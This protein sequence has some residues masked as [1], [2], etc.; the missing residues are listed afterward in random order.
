MPTPVPS[1]RACLAGEAARAL[2]DAVAVA[3]RRA[4]AQT[5]SLHVVSALLSPSFSSTLLRDALARARSAAYSPRL[6]F[7]ALELCFGVALDRLSSAHP[8]PAEPPVSNSLM[9]AIKRSQANQR[10]NPDTFHLYN[11][12]AAAGGTAAAVVKVELQPMVMAILDDPV[13]SRV[14][15]EAGFRSYDIKLSVLRPPSPIL[16]FPR[17]A[18]CPPLF[19]CNFDSPDAGDENCRR[20]CEILS[21]TT[22]NNPILVGVGA[23]DAARDFARALELQ[24]P[25]VVPPELQGVKTVNIEKGNEGDLEEMVRNS[26]GKGLVLSVGDLKGLVEDEGNSSSLVAAVTKVVTDRKAARVWVMGW[27]ATYEMYMKLLSLHPSLDKA[28]N[29]Q[30]LPITSLKNGIGSFNTRPQSLMESFVP[31]GGFFPLAYESKGSLSSQYQSIPRCQLCNEMYEQELAAMM[32][33]YSAQAEEQDKSNL[34]SWLQ[35]AET[36]TTEKGLH[37]AEA[38]DGNAMLN[39][40]IEDLQQKWNDNCKRLHR[41]FPM[42][43]TDTSRLL[44][45]LT[46]LHCVPDKGI[47]GCQCSNTTVNQKQSSRD[48]KLPISND[49]QIASASSSVSV[50]VIS[51]TKD[52][53]LSRLQVRVPEN[54][55]LQ[56]KECCSQP[57]TQ[58]DLIPDDH[59]SPSV[60]SV[61]TDLVLGTPRE[62]SQMHKERLQ[63]FSE[64]SPSKR[65]DSLAR[66]IPE[67]LQSYSYS[68]SPVSQAKVTSTV[69]NAVSPF[70]KFSENASSVCRQSDP[71]DYKAILRGLID[72]VG[73]QEEAICAIT[74]AILRCKTGPERL[75]GASLKGDIWLSFLGPDKVAKQRIAVALSELMFGSMEN[76]IHVD[77]CVQDSVVRPNVICDL[78]YI[79]GYDMKFRGK[80]ITDHIAAVVSKKPW[81]VIFLENVDKADFLVQNSLSQS[82]QTGKFSN[83]NG[84]EFSINNAIFI[85]TAKAA[86]SKTFYSNKEVAN[87]SEERILAAQRWQ[88]KILIE[89]LHESVSSSEQASVFVTKRKL[90]TMDECRDQLAFEN[91]PKQARKSRNTF[92][93][94]NLPAEEL[95]GSDTNSINTD[96]NNSLSENTEAWIEEFFELMDETVNFKPFDFNA[97]ADCIL[98]EITRNFNRI[99]GS[100]CIL[101]IDTKALEQILAATWI[102]EDRTSLNNWIETVLCRS[103]DEVKRRCHGGARSVIRLVS[104]QDAFMDE[105]A[106]GIHLPSRIA[107]KITVP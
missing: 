46:S 82:I 31:F 24:N 76:F 14:F 59:A 57:G 8:P 62:V 44:P 106:P 48:S 87:F 72:K 40:K 53:F 22:A 63:D 50:A 60:T 32:K 30:L 107:W 54:Q 101:E 27:S 100:E 61:T 13:V 103:F 58:S 42:T 81:S 66:G 19:L 23:A 77:L 20:I 7:K 88:M 36:G 39:A 56:I 47:A 86:R 15:G 90:D 11:G 65:V 9:A 105:Q 69:T 91:S 71:R 6:Q 4:H 75:R 18:R 97:L 33:T 52:N 98:K 104:C 38:K 99:M 95:L 92:L 34:P 37:G 43:E 45:H 94:L 84:R 35:S 102:L 68:C 79:N 85:T 41:G 17:S 55:Q 16:R 12:A 89:P 80:T 2:D 96:E 29:L 73:R 51:G 28:W 21:K 10:R 78:K 1:A 93:D 3:R 64:C 67:I 25:H 70:E 49:L 83:S 74:Q 26:E 5:T